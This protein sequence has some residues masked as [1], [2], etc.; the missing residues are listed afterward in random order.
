MKKLAK[1]SP[2]MKR[3]A[4]GKT[5][6]FAIGAIMWGYLSY[7]TDID[8]AFIFWILLW[9][10]ITGVLIG[11]M[12]IMHKH[13]LFG[14][15]MWWLLRGSL[16]G[17][18][19]FGTLSL[20]SYDMISQVME[21]FYIGYFKSPYWIMIDGAILGAVIDYFATKYYGQGKKLFK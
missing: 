16:I 13:P 17:A 4:L 21:V 19:M 12:W 9:C 8:T 14:F 2:L 7:L 11:A 20:V 10:S 1:M 15:K 18:M 5:I 6:G 3:I